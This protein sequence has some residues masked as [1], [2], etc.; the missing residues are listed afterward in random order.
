MTLNR[1]HFLITLCMLLMISL[2]TPQIPQNVE[3]WLTALMVGSLAAVV[4]MLIRGCRRFM[5]E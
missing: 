3:Q 5:L 4:L 2:F 1:E